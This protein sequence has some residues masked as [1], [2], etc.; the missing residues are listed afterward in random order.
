M[1]EVKM[2]EMIQ[3]EWYYIDS[4]HKFSGYSGR[5]RGLFAYINDCVAHFTQITDICHADGS[6]G[7]SGMAT[8]DRP[9]ARHCKHYRF[10]KPMVDVFMRRALVRRFINRTHYID[11]EADLFIQ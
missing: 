8:W 3:G 11:C 4:V 6:M 10:Y 7:Y 2:T 5:Q 1:L 9:G